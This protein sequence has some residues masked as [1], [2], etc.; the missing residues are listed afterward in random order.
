MFLYASF[1]SYENIKAFYDNAQLT[2][3]S[4]RTD[5]QIQI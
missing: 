5:H 4:L 1:S 3:G 2:W